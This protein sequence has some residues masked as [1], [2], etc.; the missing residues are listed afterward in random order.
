M[1][2]IDLLNKLAN[3]E[4]VPHKIKYNGYTYKKSSDNITYWTGN[5]PS[6]TLR[7]DTFDLDDEVEII[8][9]PKKIDKINKPRMLKGTTEN[10][11]KLLRYCADLENKLIEVI[12]VVNELNKKEPTK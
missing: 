2:I 7:I 11:S 4:S 6:N 3:E 9:E 8:E 1:K 5:K 12:D 10:E